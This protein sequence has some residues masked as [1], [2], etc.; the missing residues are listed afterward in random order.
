MWDPPRART[1]YLYCRAAGPPGSVWSGHEVRAFCCLDQLPSKSTERDVLPAAEFTK[2]VRQRTAW[3]TGGDIVEHLR[4]LQAELPRDE[5]VNRQADHQVAGI[6]APAELTECCRQQR[7]TQ[8]CGRTGAERHSGLSCPVPAKSEEVAVVERLHE[9]RRDPP[10][11]QLEDRPGVRLTI[12]RNP[13][14]IGFHHFIIAGM[15][16][17]GRP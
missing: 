6:T 2:Q 4:G 8:L 14:H 10:A 3:Q 1:D 7:F 15:E 16:Q 5:M 13:R 12:S 17:P 11:S 9:L